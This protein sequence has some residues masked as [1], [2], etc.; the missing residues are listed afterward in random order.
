M[1]LRNFLSQ[2]FF[3]WHAMAVHLDAQVSIGASGS[4]TLVTS[5]ASGSI[6]TSRGIY[7][8]TRL[9]TGIY[10]IRLQD[11]Y[12][13]MLDY[14][15]NFTAG[16]G[17]TVNMGSLVTGTVYRILT[18]G[19]STQAQWV[20]AGLP[21]GIT[22]AVGQVFKAAGAG[23]GNGTTKEL[24]CNAVNGIEMLTTPAGADTMLNSQPFTQTNDGGYI[25]FQ[26]RAGTGA[27]TA[28]FTGSALGTHTHTFTGDALATH[29][30]TIPVTAGTAGD[31]VTN[32]AGTLESTGGQDLTT[33]A[34]SAGTPAG[35]NS[36]TS[37]GT[38]AGT[39]AVTGTLPIAADP[40]NGS[41]MYLRFLLSNSKIG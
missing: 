21:A 4:P 1:A 31:A 11:N 26:C 5:S 29:T 35:T 20:A 16:A 3:N 32:N 40:T 39:I 15:A 2:R 24:V 6:P 41:T 19:T 10:Q 9:A 8:I 23:A 13:Q 14:K 25:T 36:A 34:T 12:S 17:S 7:S 22:A 28:A 37:A 33:S 27:A 30:H 38:P 18:I